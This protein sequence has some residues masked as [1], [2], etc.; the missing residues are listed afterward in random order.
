MI[1]FANRQQI[2]FANRQQSFGRG[3]RREALKGASLVSLFQ[4]SPQLIVLKK[5]KS[6]VRD[7]VTWKREF[8][9]G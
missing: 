6:A 2:K 4:S 3:N 8:V 1:K 5:D 7:L 9:G